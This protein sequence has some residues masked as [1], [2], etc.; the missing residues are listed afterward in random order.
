M[1]KYD[2]E[3]D[4]TDNTSTGMI[5]KKIKP[6]STVLEFGCA[7]GRMTKYMKEILGCQVYIVEYDEEAY[8]KAM[9]Y[10]KDGVCGDASKLA[11]VK[12]FES[13]KFDV[14]LF[15]DI[16]EHLLDPKEVLVNVKKLLKEDGNIYVS[17]PN[18]THNDVIL[19][20][21]NNEFEYTKVGLLD[22]THVHFWGY[23]DIEPFAD[24]CGLK[25]VD[26]EA[27]Y[28]ELGM[29]E[30]YV[31]KE[32]PFTQEFLNY[33]RERECGRVYQFIV[34]LREKNNESSN[35]VNHVVGKQSIKSHVYLD[36]GNGFNERNV[37][38][39]ETQALENGRYVAH[40]VIENVNK[41]T[42]I[43]F[44]P[45]EF[46]GCIVQNLSIRQMGKEL[47]KIYSEHIPL[48]EGVLL[49][50][51]DPMVIVTSLL[52]D[53]AI[54]I[55]ADLLI[56]GGEYISILKEFCVNSRFQ[57]EEMRTK[58]MEN[59]R[60]MEELHNKNNIQKEE[61]ESLKKLNEQLKDTVNNLNNEKDILLNES[62]KLN[63]RVI[64]FERKV[65]ENEG[66]I[67]RNKI[68]I[69][70]LQTDLGA[71][72]NLVNN[73][74]KLLIVKNKLMAE[75]E[76]QLA[77][78]EKQ[79]AENEKQL[80]ENENKLVELQDRVN[81]YD[82]RFCVRMCNKFWRNYHRVMNIFKRRKS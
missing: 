69:G 7:A 66:I 78:N 2:F 56:F 79:L 18:I 72:I 36:D 55:D 24:N 31:G 37:L 59:L 44:D 23:N 8:E 3:L 57:I 39:F 75:N 1:S 19:K 6:G 25:V 61:I 48:D 80:A 13:V 50:G 27:T 29:T 34:T 30:Q 21:F 73:K 35:L 65:L 40:Y 62:D 76:K 47:E 82:N 46:Q 14:I 70:S 28:C 58:E 54:T 53:G 33:F 74:D 12:K 81:Y 4:I 15:V 67:E 11:W 20:M 10:A 9:Q 43:R 16:L 49:L 5:I 38:E 42:Q 51:N 68:E 60:Y 45:V 26:I 63:T 52:E 32:L 41:F 64:E 22:N 71:Y 77:E 17:I